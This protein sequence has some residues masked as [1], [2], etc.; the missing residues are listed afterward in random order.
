MNTKIKPVR[1]GDVLIV[2]VDTIPETMVRTKLPVVTVALGEV[3]GHSHTIQGNVVGWSTRE[4]DPLVEFFE[5][6]D[7]TALLVHQEHEAITLSKGTYRKYIQVQYFEGM[8]V[9]NVHD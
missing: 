5:V 6:V 3:T 8:G 7:D 2:P 1:Q 9:R 4:E